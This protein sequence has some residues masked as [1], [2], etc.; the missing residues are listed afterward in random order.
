[1]SRTLDALRAAGG[2]LVLALAVLLIPATLSAGTFATFSIDSGSTTARSGAAILSPGTAVPVHLTPSAIG[3]TSGDELDALSDG[4]DAGNVVYFSVDRVSVGQNLGYGFSYGFLTIYDQHALG[5]AA[6]DLYVTTNAVY[7]GSAP[8]SVG[9]GLHI[10]DGFG[11]S[12]NQAAFGLYPTSGY[13]SKYTGGSPID[14]IDAMNFTDF[15]ISPVGGDGVADRPAFFSLGAGSPTLGSLSAGAADVLVWTPGGGLSILATA[16]QVG[17]TAGDDIDAMALVTSGLPGTP[18][19]VGLWF[20][21]APGSP[22]LGGDSAA[23]IFFS[24]FDGSYSVL[25]TAESLGLLNSD[26]VDALELQP[27]LTVT[28]EPA[29]L[30]LLALGGVGAAIGLRRRRRR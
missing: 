9:S 12:G 11:P 7:A 16:A 17:L 1:M 27:L 21:L 3:L 6:A 24:R 28:P 18:T 25:Y 19:P 13:A 10:L 14:N 23:D 8:P 2:S 5:H 22:S 30:A 15:D 26:N 4:Q 20:S 29:T